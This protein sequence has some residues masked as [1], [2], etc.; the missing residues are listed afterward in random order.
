M[1]LCNRGFLL[2]LWTSRKSLT[3]LVGSPVY[4]PGAGILQSTISEVN[5]LLS[6]AGTITAQLPALLPPIID[7]DMSDG[8]AGYP[9]PGYG[10][11]LHS[12]RRLVSSL[13]QIY[14][15]L[16]D[17][18]VALASFGHPYGC[19]RARRSLETGD[20]F[21]Q[22]SSFYWISL[23]L[24]TIFSQRLH[25][26]G[27][28]WIYRIAFAFGYQKQIVKTNFPFH[29]C[30]LRSFSWHPC[31]C[32]LAQSR[33]AVSP[34]WSGVPLLDCWYDVDKANVIFMV[35]SQNTKQSPVIIV[36]NK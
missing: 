18:V 31:P 6:T 27:L 22:F 15:I 23:N 34:I 30:I 25:F 8:M 11:A 20:N 19:F 2:L 14:Q 35:L 3:A 36:C 16:V 5:K 28:Y 12:F 7:T 21:V 32:P 4:V 29:K 13:W 24:F 10:G 17:R 1:A 26:Y 9:V 33:R